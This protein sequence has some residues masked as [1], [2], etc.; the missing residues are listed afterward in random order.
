[1]GWTL[2]LALYFIIWWVVLFAVLPIG[3]RTQG[4]DGLV[5]PGTPSSAPTTPRLMK[6]AGTTTLVAGLVFALVW[7]LVTKPTIRA[8]ICD[9]SRGMLCL[10][11]QTP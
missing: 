10:P 1:M 9:Y 5:V 6:I 11:S 4:E 2:G 8:G 7:L 3:V